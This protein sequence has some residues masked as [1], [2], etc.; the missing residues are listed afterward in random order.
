MNFN[1][2]WNAHQGDVQ[3]HSID[4]LPE[5][6]KPVEKTFFAMSEKTGH[7]HAMS[8]DYELFELENG[9]HVISVGTDGCV[10]NHTGMEN[11]TPEYWDKGDATTVADHQPTIVPPGIYHVGIQRRLNPYNKIW[12]KVKD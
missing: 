2:K 5:G 9:S 7:V 3:I 4:K 1:K 6:A 10:L 12:E 11:L 8:G